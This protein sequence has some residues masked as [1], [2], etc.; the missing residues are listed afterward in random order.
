M[1]DHHRSSQA[2]NN[3]HS[4]VLYCRG[5][6]HVI[7]DRIGTDPHIVD[8]IQDASFYRIYQISHIQLDW[9][10]VTAF[11]ERWRSETHTFHLS[12]GEASITLQDVAVFYR[13]PI[14]RRLIIGYTARL[15]QEGG[16]GQGRALRRIRGKLLGVVP[17]EGEMVGAR[18][19]MRFLKG[20]MF[21]QLPTAADDHTVVCHARAHLLQLICGMLFCDL[22]GSYVHLMFLPLLTTRAEI[23]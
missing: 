3:S 16:A 14:D 12:H 7:H 5:G 6:T 9:H 20:K 8:W 4:D 15:V 17:L 1:G 13:I 21:C 11:V 19:R 2:W 23:R 22:S 18:I 10:L